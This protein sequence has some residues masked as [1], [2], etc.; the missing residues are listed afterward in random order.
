MVVSLSSW[1]LLLLGDAMRTLSA[2]GT[3]RKLGPADF[4]RHVAPE[5]SATGA[6]Q[7]AVPDVTPVE[8]RAKP[9]GR[10]AGQIGPSRI[11]LA[12][13]PGVRRLR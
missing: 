12:L 13:N 7:G 1:I 4:F 2:G 11:S 9:G 10:I 6:I 8:Q 5:S 3:M